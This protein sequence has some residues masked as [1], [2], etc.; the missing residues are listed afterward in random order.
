MGTELGINNGHT[1]TTLITESAFR[2]GP[3]PTITF[4][5]F[6]REALSF[7]AL[8]PISPSLPRTA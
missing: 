6:F 1:S 3:S 4:S 2:R 7:V 8:H 5:C